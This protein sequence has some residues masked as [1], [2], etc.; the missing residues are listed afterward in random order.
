MVISR[1]ETGRKDPVDKVEA[2]SNPVNKDK[3]VINKIVVAAISKIS[4][5]VVIK[6]TVRRNLLAEGNQQDPVDK[7]VL[8]QHP[9]DK[10]PVAIR[11][12]IIQTDKVVEISPQD[13]VDRGKTV[14]GQTEA[15]AREV[16]N[17]VDPVDKDK[18]K[19]PVITAGIKNN[20]VLKRTSGFYTRRF[21]I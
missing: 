21:L 20:V 6:V 18:I 9:V 16:N 14:T 10:T 5:K 2:T 4:S 13:P 8:L 12:T 17:P 1:E 7:I 3:T 11:E 19:T 15:A